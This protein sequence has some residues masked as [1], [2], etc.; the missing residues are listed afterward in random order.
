MMVAEPKG[1]ALCFAISPDG[2]TLAAGCTDKSVYLLDA[3]TGERK[4]AL[5][6]TQR[7]YIRGV[8]FALEGK[9]VVGVS[10]DNRLRLWDVASGKIV[11]A[12]PA[13]G[14]MEQVGLPPIMP[15]SLAI[16]PDGARIAVGGS[17]TTDKSHVTHMDD[18][19]FFEMR[20]LDAESGVLVWSH[21][22][23]RGYLDQLVFS[24]DGKI[25]ASATHGEVKLW[26]SRGGDLKQTL[27]PKSGTVWAIA[28]SP[29]NRLL[30][31]YGTAVV[32]DRRGSWL[33]VWDV[34]SGAIVHS[35]DAGEAGGATAPGTLAFSPDG[36]TLAS[37]AVGIAQGR[38]SIGGRDVGSGQK[39][40]NYIK[41][42]DVATG[43]TVWTSAAGD[44]GDVTSLVFSPDGGS[45][46]C[47]DLSATSR[48]DARTGQ[49]R[50]DLMKADQRR[51]R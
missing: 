38:I 17:G 18:S 39:V 49:T 11:K 29:D 5:S 42:W 1:R 16:S 36:K 27:K 31:G 25:L 21:L 28:F 37:A 7:G 50:Q 44:Y 14:D 47:C 20:V 4:I 32:E 33:T 10:D 9:A 51:G 34:R 2:G 30:A 19:T 24:P 40:I 35:I 8:V 22:G 45:L 15:S 23:R 3:G 6:G 48:I 43:A 12:I 46:F 41:L 13:V 26:D